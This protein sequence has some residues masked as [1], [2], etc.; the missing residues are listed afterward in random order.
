[1]AKAAR[2]VA[3]RKAPP[4]ARRKVEAV[5]ARLGSV[6]SYLVIRDCARALEFYG[7]A[8]GAKEL[9]RMSGPDGKVMH[10]EVRIGNRV[11]LMAEEMP[12]V[13]YGSP[14][15]I[16]GTTVTLMLYVPDCDKVYARALEAGA[17]E[18]RPPEDMFWGDRYSQ[19]L[20]PFGH[21]WAIATH[22]ADLTKKQLEA[23]Q[24]DFMAKM[25]GGSAP[26]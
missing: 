8:F 16:G 23:A 2:K 21:R 25:A 7:R 13:G 4:A 10:A 14:E 9:T 17:R 15:S 6:S 24:A 11:V 3:R 1:M 20:D 18:L 22:R 5:P 26:G 12:A 19:V